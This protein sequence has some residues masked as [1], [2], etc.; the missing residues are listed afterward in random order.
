MNIAF[1][2]VF[3]YLCVKT[4]SMTIFKIRI[5]YSVI[6]S[7]LDTSN[8]SQ[9]MSLSFLKIFK[10]RYT[11]QHLKHYSFRNYNKRSYRYPLPHKNNNFTGVELK[12]L[13]SFT[14]F[15]LSWGSTDVCWTSLLLV[16]RCRFTLG[17]YMYD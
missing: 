7:R 11:G 5:S 1:V 4:T 9:N 15:P 14:H 10:E 8:F 3:I 17:L 6:A 13:F 2:S 16:Y 12:H